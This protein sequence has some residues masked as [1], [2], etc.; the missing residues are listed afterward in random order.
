AGTRY[1]YQVLRS[2]GVTGYGYI[3]SGID[4]PLVDDRGK[5]VLV[6]DSSMSA[7]LATELTRLIQDLAGDGCTVL[8]HD[9]SRTA[10]VPSVKALIKADYLADPT[11]VNAIFLFGHVPVPYSGDIAPDGH[12]NHIGAWPADI[13][14]ADM[15]GTWTD[16]ANYGGTGR[17]NNVPGD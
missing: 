4:V 2:A 11:H 15:T 7:P 17:Q 13:Y 16:T 14:Y 9:V 12:S 3:A 8:R 5:V 1:E 6:V 10:S